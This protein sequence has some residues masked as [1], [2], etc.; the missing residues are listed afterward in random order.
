MPNN[1]KIFP[2]RINGDNI[3]LIGFMGSGKTSVA[4]KIAEKTNYSFVDTDKII[5][6]ENNL[7]IKDIFN[8]YGEKY[9][10]DCEKKIISYLLKMEFP[11]VIATGGG[12]PCYLNRGKINDLK[13][14]GKIFFLKNSKKVLIK[15]IL[16]DNNRPL[17][18]VN[19]LFEKRQH[20]Y[21]SVADYI[22][23]CDAK[24]IDEISEEILLL[25]NFKELL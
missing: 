10:R 5:E 2:K 13:K 4:K 6:R 21:K 8:I 22:I 14:I 15:R 20:F 16:N 18:F 7:S 11:L 12:F 24:S 17:R 19:N 1:I 23:S 9:F 25:K 3:I